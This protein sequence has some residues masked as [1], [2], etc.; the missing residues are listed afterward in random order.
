MRTINDNL[1]RALWLA[2][3]VASGFLIAACGGGTDPL[4]APCDRSTDCETSGQVCLEGF[5]QTCTESAAC[6]ADSNYLAEG[7][8][9]CREGLCTA[10]DSGQ[11]GCACVDGSCT[12]GECVGEVCVDCARGALGCICRL[13]GTCDAGGVCGDGLCTQ[14]TPGSE[15]C[16]CGSGEVCDGSLSCRQGTCVDANCTD[17]TVDCPCDVAGECL[18]GDVYCDGTNTCR[19]CASDVPGCPCDGE[20]ACQGDNYCGG[21][22]CV[23]CPETEK[24]ETCGCTASAQ[25]AGDLVCDMNQLVCRASIDCSQLDCLPNQLC[26]ADL[27]GDFGGDA[28]CVPESCVPGFYWD[29]AACAEQGEPCLDGS[30]EPTATGQQ[31]ARDN[32][33]CVDAAMGG[34][35]VQ[36]CGSLGC[37]V[38]R[39]DCM[40]GARLEDDALCLGCE[41][42]Y[43]DMGGICMLDPT[44][45][46]VEGVPGSISTDCAMRGRDCVTLEGG[47]A[48]GACQAGTSVNP[49]T[50]QCE[51]ARA[52]GESVCFDGQF[53]FY[54]QAGSTPQCRQRCPDGQAIDVNGQCVSCGTLSCGEGRIFGAQVDGQCACEEEVFCADVTDGSELRCRVRPCPDG[55]AGPVG[56]PMNPS[57]CTSCSVTCGDDPGESDRIWPWRDPFAQCFC[58]TLDDYYRPLGVN[59]LPAICDNDADGWIAES[60]ELVYDAASNPPQGGPDL[61]TLANF[62]CARRTVDRVRLVNEYGQSRNVGLC[63]DAI[64]DW[65][66]STSAADACPNGLTTVTMFENDEL[67]NDNTLM[68][69]NTKYPAFGDRKLAASELNAL[70]KACVSF[71]GDFN[72]NGVEDVEEVQPAQRSDVVGVSVQDEDV[73]FGAVSYFLEL[74]TSGYEPGVRNAPGTYVVSERSRCEMEFP[75]TY[76]VGRDGYWTSCTRRRRG[77]Y[78]VGDAVG[79]LGGDFGQFSCGQET[80]TCALEAPVGTGMSVDGDDVEDHDL[81]SLRDAGQLPLDDEP[82]LGMTH[83]SQFQCARISLG[84]AK[85]RIA[86]DLLSEP[87][88]LDTAYDFNDCGAVSCNGEAGCVESLSQSEETNQPDVPVISCRYAN[89]AEVSTDQV[90]FVARR[91]LQS[92]GPYERGC[93][94]E[95]KDTIVGT[96]IGSP[97]VDQGFSRFCPGFLTN[98]ESVLTA[99]NRGDFGKLICSCSVNYAGA[100][101]EVSCPTRLRRDD[102]KLHVGGMDTPARTNLTGRQLADYG[103]EENGFCALHA[104]VEDEAFGGGRRGYWMC[105]EFASS[106]GDPSGLTGSGAIT[107]GA[108]QAIELVGVVPQVPMVRVPL[109]TSTTACSSGGPCFR[110]AGGNPRALRLY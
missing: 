8:T 78:D 101:C 18:G 97:E 80:G 35:C 110:D 103:C 95:S 48:C 91:F 90:G 1:S 82:W 21:M 30:G 37:A 60:A 61:A 59:A 14:C 51:P 53:C 76:T 72:A 19:T 105:G 79:R 74:H 50:G 100:D 22:D 47:A 89:R 29:G 69:D 17:G 64:V 27:E 44:G 86:S 92:P 31:C 85:N 94:D 88:V 102:R 42:G 2:L 28:I 7:R 99:A 11:V 13:N 104:P 93:I 56:G 75:L 23:A 83:H 9:Q 45:T 108:P 26:E 20:D 98:F 106:T 24:P 38:D 67:E 34:Q 36:T 55:T 52:C 33:V 41:P 15:N 16:P 58:E 4:G 87:G 10:C 109:T 40:P 39:R 3:T 46:C 107:G 62:R 63:G 25:C 96:P 12:S 43:V 77:D 32:Q 49:R 71:E 54:P 66:P 65:A 5:C 57:Q 84:A 73:L 81:C 6:V 70:T 68:L